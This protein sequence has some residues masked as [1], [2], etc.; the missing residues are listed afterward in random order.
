MVAGTRVNQQ[1]QRTQ[2]GFFTD[3]EN[4]ADKIPQE[5]VLFLFL[6]FLQNEVAFTTLYLI[7]D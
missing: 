5:A 3:F 7:A 1:D 4:G 2:A 6:F